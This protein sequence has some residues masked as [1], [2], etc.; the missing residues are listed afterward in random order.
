[1]IRVVREAGMATVI[2]DKTVDAVLSVADRVIVLVKGAVVH[3]GAPETLRA[4]PDLMSRY[5]GVEG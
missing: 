1:V 4:D 5:L 3:D 2:V